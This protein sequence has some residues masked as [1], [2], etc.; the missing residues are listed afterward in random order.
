MHIGLFAPFVTGY[1]DPA[2]TLQAARAA[3]DLGFH[4]LWVPEHV[5]LFDEYKSRYPY[6]TDSRL[7]VGDEAAILGPLPF[8]AYLASGTS[9]IRL[10][11]GILLVPQ[12]NPVYTAKDTATVDWLSGGRLDIGVGIGWLAEEFAAL[13]VPWKQRSQRT[14]SYIQV[15]RA[16]WTEPVSSHE[17]NFYS[18]PPSRQFPKPVQKPHP[19]I[20][21]GGE[22]DAALQRTAEFGQGW[23]GYDLTPEKAEERV[24]TL[25]RLLEAKNR[26]RED[27]TV[28]VAPNVPRVD[29]A[30]T[31]DYALA[32]VDQIILAG[33]GRDPNDYLER[34]AQMAKDVVEPASRLT[35]ARA[36]TS[37][38]G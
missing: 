2:F 22:S 36:A 17:D 4:S 3:E 24:Q 18:L 34:L 26:R 29:A 16:L 28:S 10:G 31:E 5:L 11:T 23:F 7:R 19:P 14:R 30:L 8:L 38:R 1:V 32:G 15:M 35:P 9:R 6:A 13:D 37:E 25:T 33:R 27:V 12:R 20:H 21:F